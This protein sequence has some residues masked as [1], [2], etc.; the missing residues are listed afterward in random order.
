MQIGSK[1]VYKHAL[2]QKILKRL[3]KQIINKI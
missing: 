3:A 2:I 1:L